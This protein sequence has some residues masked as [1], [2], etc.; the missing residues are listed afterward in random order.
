MMKRTALLA[1]LIGIVA[2]GATSTANAAV[3]FTASTTVSSGNPLT[4][5][6]PGDVVTIEVEL[7]SDGEQA[8]GLG[9]AATGYDS[10]L[11][12]FTSGQTVT[13]ALAAVCTGG[14]CFGGIDNSIVTIEES[15][16]NPL[17]PEVQFFNGVSTSG[18]TN[19]GDI[20]LGYNGVEGD[21]QFQLVFTVPAGAGD[22][23]F[24][25]TLGALEE[26]GDA[27][28]ITGGARGTS[29]NAVLTLTVP[30]PQ[31]YAAGLVGIGSVILAI[32]MRRRS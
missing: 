16:A 6:A 26:Y 28:I 14:S 17:G 4:A 3:T 31:A 30:E 1:S 12:E 20:D 32:R 11:L 8:F 7:R 5:L 21:P 15:T 27:L 25:L 23:T 9:G 13:G 22:G 2:F 24:D 29:N 10:S 19:T 18:T